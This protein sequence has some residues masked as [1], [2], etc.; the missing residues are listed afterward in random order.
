MV[1]EAA[2]IV[3]AV[4]SISTL[5]VV[6]ALELSAKSKTVMPR[7]FVPSVG[8]D[9]TVHMPVYSDPELRVKVVLAVQTE[10]RF[11]VAFFIP[12]PESVS[13]DLRVIWS[14]ALA[15]VWEPG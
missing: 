1:G 11:V 7:E 4:L 9:W 3:G 6:V 13:V 10:P 12:V 8:L 15:F 5:R 14:P 2:I